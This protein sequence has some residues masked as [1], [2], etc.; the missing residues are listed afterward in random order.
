VTADGKLEVTLDEEPAVAG[1]TSVARIDGAPFAWELSEDRYTVRTTAPIATGTHDLVILDFGPV[2]L[3]GKPLVQAITTAFE[4][5]ETSDVQTLYALPIPGEVEISTV[6]NVLGFHGLTHD[7]ETDLVYVRNRY[8][9][10]RMG[11]FLT[12]D[13]MGYADSV[14]LYQ[15]ALND[16]VNL[17]DPTGAWVETAWDA[18]SLGVGAVSFAYNLSEGNY[19]AATLDAVGIAVD[20]VATA[21]PFVPG[22]AGAGIKAIRASS[23]FAKLRYVD[24]TA[25]FAQ[26]VVQGIDEYSQGNCGWGTLYAG[27]AVVGARQQFASSVRPVAS[28]AGSTLGNLRFRNAPGA[29]VLELDGFRL[30][31]HGDMPSPRPGTESHHGLMSRW[32]RE[33]YGLYDADRAPAVL[34]PTEAHNATR[35]VYNRWRAEMR[36]KMGG[37]FE[38]SKVSEADMRTLGEKMFHASG[39]PQPIQQGYWQWFERMKGAL[40]R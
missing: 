31:R 15:F 29:G 22:G 6:G 21:V 4:V 25:S 17:S 9:D 2:D 35:G 11:R 34:M 7:P 27:M 26:G 1:W 20:A 10:P 28:G 36:R 3:D 40:E 13:P 39:T 30:A 23:G 16:P 12:T 38:W 5:S 37:T 33:R 8:L 32:M 18:T 19:G 14:S 24:Q